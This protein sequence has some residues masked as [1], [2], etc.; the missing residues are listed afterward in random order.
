M[1]LRRWQRT[2]AIAMGLLLAGGLVTFVLVCKSKAHGLVTN[3]DRHA[4]NA[5]QDTRRLSD[6]A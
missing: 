3:P 5:A 2:T 1:P 6:A 4:A